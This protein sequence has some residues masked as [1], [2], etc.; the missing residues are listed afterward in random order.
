MRDWSA[1]ELTYL[2]KR[3]GL[4]IRAL[5]WVT[6]RDRS[7]GLPQTMGLWTGEEDR[8]FV[9]GGVTRLYHGAGPF[10]GIEPI[11]MTTGVQVRMQRLQLASFSAEVQQLALGYDVSLAPVEIH[12]ALYD[13][14]TGDLIDEPRLAW[15][16]QI[17][18]LPLPTAE[19]GGEAVADVQLASSARDLTRGLTLTKSDAVQQLR[20]G[21]RF[22]RYQD[23]TGKVAVVWGAKRATAGTAGGSATRDG[24]GG[25]K[26]SSH[27]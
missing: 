6:A 9:I 19:V 26:G 10:I 2:Q 24:I 18:Q 22:R 1:P 3:G 15:K 11:V 12:R 13:P 14:E 8:E 23:V 25:W 7:T 16:G 17:D 5:V 21:D 4:M 20:G 27:A